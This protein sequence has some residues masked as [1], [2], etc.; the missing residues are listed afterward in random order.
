MA[1]IVFA[2][3]EAPEEVLAMMA[4]DAGGNLYEIEELGD[5]DDSGNDKGAQDLEEGERN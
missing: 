4:I 5:G 2:I 1:K 3:D